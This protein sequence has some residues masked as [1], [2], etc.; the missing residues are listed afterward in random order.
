MR[1]AARTFKTLLVA[2]IA[3]AALAAPA[4]AATTLGQT[5]TP[6]SGGCGAD[7]VLF[8]APS[9]PRPLNVP[10]AG[11]ITSFTVQGDAD[12]DVVQ[13]SILRHTGG[14]QYLVVAESAD[15]TVPT[16]QLTTIPVRI[17]V[18]A[19][20]LL[21]YQGVSTTGTF[22]CASNGADT[23]IACVQPCNPSAGATEDMSVS[24]SG[25]TVNLQ[26]QLENDAD[27]DGYGDDTQDKCPT[28]K[29][30]VDVGCDVNIAM[31]KTVSPATV[32]PG[33]NAIFTA[34]V[35]NPT[36][37]AANAVVVTDNVPAQLRV[38][39]ASSN[40]GEECVV[41]GNTVTCNVGALA[42]DQ[43]ARVTIVV[44]ALTAGSAINT[45]T[46]TTSTPDIDPS[47]NSA[48]ATVT[49]ATPVAPGSCANARF[50]T[51]A[52][53]TLTGTLAGDNIFGLQG[54]DVMDGAAGAD[55]L[56]GG[57][58]NDTLKGGDGND[59][60]FGEDGNDKLTGGKGT[61]KFSGGAGNDT[62]NARDGKKETIDCG[63]GKDTA[64]VD[65]ADTVKGCETVKR[66]KK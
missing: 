15:S 64:T 56:F 46:A 25:I 11:I 8:T 22:G 27:G 18:Q 57:L 42:K 55:C 10:S 16:G 47:N 1:F 43:S 35:T 12:S 51:K 61:D 29:S 9:S 5:T 23:V 24:A 21:A 63:A 53:D 58:G 39:S 28:D 41:N 40:R 65:K 66:A 4:Q 49:I 13:L 30:K 32:A 37:G 31:T 44:R 54:N 3:V 19:G 48:S 33:D 60:L 2:A 34:T 14:T 6:P 59:Q 17:A 36:P 38:V 20:D 62:V 50:G 26:A 7:A 45:A 52:K